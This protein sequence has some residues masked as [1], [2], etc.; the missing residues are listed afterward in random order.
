MIF[1]RADFVNVHR[2]GKRFVLRVDEKLTAFVELEAAICVSL[3]TEQIYRDVG[4]HRLVTRHWDRKSANGCH[5]I[6]T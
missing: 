3:L 6:V 2:D 1:G 4:S 5:A